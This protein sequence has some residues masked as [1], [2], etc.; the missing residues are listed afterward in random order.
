MPFFFGHAHGPI[1]E[2]QQFLFA[3][4]LI[5]Y[6][7]LTVIRI[8]RLTDEGQKRRESF[9]LRNA[10]LAMMFIVSA[11]LVYDMF[12]PIYFAPFML[13]AFMGFAVINLLTAW[14]L[15]R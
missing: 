6:V 14:Y 1:S 13:S 9:A 4:G 12:Y 3:L 8:R 11:L 5:I 7:I 15:Q 10:G 2:S